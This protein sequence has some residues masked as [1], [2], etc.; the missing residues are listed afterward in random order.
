MWRK[1]PEVVRGQVRGRRGD[2]KSGRVTRSESQR[3]KPGS[4]RQGAGGLPFCPRVPL[5]SW[6]GLVGGEQARLV[7]GMT[8]RQAGAGGGGARG[9][10]GRRRASPMTPPLPPFSPPRG[11]AQPLGAFPDFPGGGAVAGVESRSLTYGRW[12]G[13]LGGPKGARGCVLHPGSVQ[14]ARRVFLVLCVSPGLWIS[15]PGLHPSASSPALSPCLSI[16]VC[17]S[18]SPSW[19]PENGCKAPGSQEGTSPKTGTPP[20]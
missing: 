17:I 16:S 5:P 18:V 2:S 10:E 3:P 15:F 11:G 19:D 12:S 7:G 6:A 14:A 8:Q 1:G 13:R 4:R 9:R 20:Q